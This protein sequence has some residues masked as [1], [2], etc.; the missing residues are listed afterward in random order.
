MEVDKNGQM[1]NV[2]ED[3]IKQLQ[4]ELNKV[5]M[6][7]YPAAVK[8]WEC[9]KCGAVMSPYTS[10]CT[11]CRGN[12]TYPQWPQYPTYPTTPW[13]WNPWYYDHQIIC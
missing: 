13:P 11:N 8:G 3:D 7:S 10:T 9:P 4:E 1:L 5:P 6:Q 12:T 2:T